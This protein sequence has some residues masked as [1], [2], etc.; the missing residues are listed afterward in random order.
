MHLLSGEIT[1][2]PELW[3]DLKGH[4]TW[5]ICFVWNLAKIFCGFPAY[6]LMKSFINHLPKLNQWFDKSFHLAYCPS[7]W[8]IPL[9]QHDVW[10]LLS[11]WPYVYLSGN[12]YC[13]A[14]AHTGCTALCRHM[15]GITWWGRN[16][17]HELHTTANL[18]L[19]TAMND[20]SNGVNVVYISTMNLKLQTIMSKR[21]N[22]TPL[23]AQWGWSLLSEHG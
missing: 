2:K 11:I 14:K 10:C 8:H 7:H 19:Y 21:C 22:A 15:I 5:C 20:Y 3:G 18:R 17:L 6:C 23:I 4:I 12:S 9:S 16:P 1:W 13:C